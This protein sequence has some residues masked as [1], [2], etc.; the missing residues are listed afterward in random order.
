MGGQRSQ[1]AIRELPSSWDLGFPGHPSCRILGLHP[2]RRTGAMDSPPS[3]P[4]SFRL[5][6]WHTTPRTDRTLEKT[7]RVAWARMTAPRECIIHYR[8][9]ESSMRRFL[10]S[11]HW[12][13]S[14]KWRW[15]LAA[16]AR[17]A[18][19][20]LNVVSLLRCPDSD[21]AQIAMWVRLRV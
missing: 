21:L 1:K 18:L 6:P 11:K 16:R 4:S 9:R 20:S 15:Q 3:S 19:S 8:E 13:L 14:A 5:Q 7:L 10:M 2:R 17:S 12:D